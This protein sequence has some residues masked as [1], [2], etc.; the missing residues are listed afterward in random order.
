MTIEDVN[1][2]VDDGHL[3]DFQ[4]CC[5]RTENSLLCIDDLIALPVL[6]TCR[7]VTNN[8][9]DR[10]IRDSNSNLIGYLVT[11]ANQDLPPFSQLTRY[12]QIALLADL[13]GVTSFIGTAGYRFKYDYIVV[14]ANRYYEYLLDFK[15]SSPVWG[16]FCHVDD[17]PLNQT[18]VVPQTIVAYRCFEYPTPSHH[19]C[20]TISSQETYA[21]EAFLRLYHLLELSFDYDLV[22]KI[23]SL[24][25]DMRNIGK[26]LQ[27][28]RKSEFDCLF[29]KLAKVITVN[30][31]IETLL[32]MLMQPPYK[33]TITQLIFDYPRDYC[34]VNDSNKTKFNMFVTSGIYSRPSF[35]T[36]TVTNDYDSFTKKFVTYL[37]Y[38]I[39]CCIAHQRIGEYVMDLND[40]P[41]VNDI[42]LPLLRVVLAQA[43][44]ARQIKFWLSDNGTR[45]NC[46][47]RF[48]GRQN[49][50][51]INK[52]LG[53]SCKRCGG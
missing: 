42:M 40:E 14:C 34:P 15:R 27:E 11:L 20:A 19:L 25:T 21:L 16:G 12:R 39:R 30:Q 33:S 36:A 5:I 26:V 13:S 41:F 37:I 24:G 31:Y 28:S 52:K 1:K 8:Q 9:V 7:L 38:R 48:Y 45:H 49:G 10:E 32:S 6:P 46:T 51:V 50:K 35:L 23:K 44:C 18:I 3:Q 22:I 29:L 17:A 47:C 2:L 4:D 43:Y 53:H